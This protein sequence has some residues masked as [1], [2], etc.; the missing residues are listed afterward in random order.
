MNLEDEVESFE[1]KNCLQYGNKGGAPSGMQ[2]RGAL[3][4]KTIHF[5]R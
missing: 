5:Y 3:G 4:Q 1:K 2:N